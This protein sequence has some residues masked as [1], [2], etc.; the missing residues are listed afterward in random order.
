MIVTGSGA[1]FDENNSNVESIWCDME[2]QKFY[3][4]LPELTVFLPT[5]YLK[6]QPPPAPVETVT[7][8]VLDSDLGAEAE[9]TEEDSKLCKFI[10]LFAVQNSI[11]VFTLFYS[12]FV[13][14]VLICFE[15]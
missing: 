8:E 7:E 15:R 5:A 2:T 9:D 4:D 10:N 1:D 6:N 3:C 11:F 12:T 13:D 14:F